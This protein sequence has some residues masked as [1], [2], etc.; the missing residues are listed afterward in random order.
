MTTFDPDTLEKDVEVLRSI[1]RRFEG[2]LAL[3]CSVLRGGEVRL[4]DKVE[5]V[6]ESWEGPGRTGAEEGR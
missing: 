4:A 1:H 6:D 3:N 2:T 5:L